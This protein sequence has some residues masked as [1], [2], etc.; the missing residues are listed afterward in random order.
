M[1]RQRPIALRRRTWSAI[2]APQESAALAE[3]CRALFEN[4]GY[5]ASKPDTDAVY[6]AIYDHDA[7]GCIL[8]IESHDPIT[9]LVR[10]IRRAAGEVALSHELTG[11]ERA[12]P[13]HGKSYE[14]GYTFRVLSASQLEDD[15]THPHGDFDETGSHFIWQL[16]G[17]EPGERAW[18]GWFA[19]VTTLAP[20]VLAFVRAIEAAGA[21]TIVREGERWKL[22]VSSTATGKQLFFATD[23]ELAAI[24]AATTVTSSS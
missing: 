11:S 6:A 9:P 1:S 8:L 3:L 16:V 2:C 21:W 14:K 18:D 15:L 5:R 4:N 20:R 24:R 22:T 23:A 10:E 19:A 17:E 12:V 7:D 13:T